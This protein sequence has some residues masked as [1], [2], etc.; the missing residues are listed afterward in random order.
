MSDMTISA[1]AT[2]ILA[3]F[4]R[5]PH[6]VEAATR[7]AAEITAR[8]IVAEAQRRVARATGQTAREI[9]MHP[10][11]DG[12]GWYVT[13]DNTR[14]PNLVLWLEFG[15]KKGKRGSHASEARP[16]FFVAA[17][18]EGSSH[19]RRMLD[20]INDVISEIGLAA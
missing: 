14:M 1:D 11:S 2:E 10:T 8:N 12:K 18:L 20:A 19:E 6:E 17:Q 16:Y 13:T 9:T 15:T 7:D 4:E 5:F 3:A